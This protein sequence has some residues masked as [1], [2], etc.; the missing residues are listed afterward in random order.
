[1]LDRWPKYKALPLNVAKKC[2]CCKVKNAVYLMDAVGNPYCKK[3]LCPLNL[4]PF[5]DLARV[6]FFALK[7]NPYS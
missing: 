4:K 7:V 6:G 5:A 1:M 2:E 3:T